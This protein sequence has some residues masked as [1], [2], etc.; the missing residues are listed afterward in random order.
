M[1]GL[2]GKPFLVFLILMVSFALPLFLLP[3]HI[4]P[5]EIVHSVGTKEIVAPADLSLSYFIGIG[6]NEGDLDGVKDFY[7]LPKGKI[8]AL[9]FIVGLP[10]ILGYRL[11]LRKNQ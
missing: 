1:K 7:L 9:I 2:L 10:A 11:K 3:I 5:G 8:L 6:I 4:F